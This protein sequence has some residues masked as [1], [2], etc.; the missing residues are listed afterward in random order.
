MNGQLDV[1]MDKCFRKYAAALAQLK[2]DLI[3]RRLYHL[4]EII[5]QQGALAG[6]VLSRRAD[7]L[8]SNI[9]TQRT[10]LERASDS[11]VLDQYNN[12]M[13]TQRRLRREL[14]ECKRAQYTLR[15]TD[16]NTAMSD[17]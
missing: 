11:R 12:S 9:G 6:D 13:A 5:V 8:G 16:T 14:I 7:L 17:L 1:A 2:A 4:T 10:D 15:N 3:A